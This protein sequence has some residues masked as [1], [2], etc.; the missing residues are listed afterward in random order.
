MGGGGRGGVITVGGLAYFSYRLDLIMTRNV[1]IF[2]FGFSFALCWF[3]FFFLPYI[4]SLSL[5][6]PPFFK[7]SADK[8]Y[9]YSSRIM[10]SCPL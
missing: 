9:T 7:V 1:T 10:L 5:S 4:F 2:T 6:F 3:S 8:R